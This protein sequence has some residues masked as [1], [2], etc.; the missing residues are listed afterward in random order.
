M[1]L[2]LRAMTETDRRFVVPTWAYG[3]KWKGLSLCEKFARVDSILADEG[4]RVVCLA[5][6]STVHAWAAGIGSRL[7]YAYVPAWTEV[8]GM[9]EPLRRL[10]L[11]RKVITE[12]LGGYPEVIDITHPWP[13]ASERFR[14]VSAPKRKAA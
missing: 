8:D 2:A 13:F 9:R 10:G 1:T 12:L 7:H 4:T 11:A 5:G 3:A 14:L 6:G